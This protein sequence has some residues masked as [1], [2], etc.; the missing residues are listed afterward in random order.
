MGEKEAQLW[1]RTRGIAW[2]VQTPVVADVPGQTNQP[3]PPVQTH[4]APP[5]RVDNRQQQQE[6]DA[7]NRQAAS[8]LIGDL[9]KL[10]NSLIE[11]HNNR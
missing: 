7:A 6:Q 3:S 4:A 10:Q 2:Q 11:N 9:Q 1:L 5:L 8:Q